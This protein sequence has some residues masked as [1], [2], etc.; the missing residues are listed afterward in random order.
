MTIDDRPADRPASP[1]PRALIV[2][3]YGL[4]ARRTSGWLAVSTLIQLMDDL[5]VEEPAVRSAISRLKR[6][7]VLL[8]RPRD[9]IAGYELSEQGSGI[10]AEGD[11]RIFRRQRTG[12]DDG[13]VLAVFSVPESER[14]RRHQLRSRLSWLGFGTVSAGVWVAPAHLTE[15]TLDVLH[16][17]QLGDYVDLFRADHVG[18]ADPRAEVARWWDL[19]DL[20]RMYQEFVVVH[21][22]VL[23]RWSRRRTPCDRAAFSD[24]VIALTAWRRLPYLDPGLPLEALPP[25]WPGARAAAVFDALR[26]LLGPAAER[27]IARTVEGAG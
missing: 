9:G 14:R 1:Q 7:G 23:R 25:R 2:T 19:D 12:L 18:G 16:R 10:L 15:Q 20:A 3:V 17:E 13:W 4:Y 5:G 21:A 27:H 6:R 11:E 26:D 22:P 8:A 24:Y